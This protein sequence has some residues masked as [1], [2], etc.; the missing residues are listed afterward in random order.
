MARGGGRRGGRG[1]HE[2]TGAAAA[3]IYP[4]S[5][6]SPAADLLPVADLR[7]FLAGSW[8]LE[9]TIED[10]GNDQR[11]TVRGTAEFVADGSGIRWIEHGTV[12]LAGYVGE[13][14]RELEIVPDPVGDGWLVRFDDGR[15]F[16]PLDLRSGSCDAVHP[17]RADRYVGQVRATSSASFEVDWQV[18]GPAKDQRIRTRYARLRPDEGRSR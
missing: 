10:R 15:P 11:G 6:T 2:A 7:A 1:A 3:T 18:T 12:Q 9:R 5:V 17:C 14:S 8:S 16:H 4:G 13:A